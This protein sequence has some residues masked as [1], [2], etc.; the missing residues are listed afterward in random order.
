MGHCMVTCNGKRQREHAKNYDELVTL[1]Q[2]KYGP[3][4]LGYL[5]K[6]R[7]VRFDNKSHFDRICSGLVSRFQEGEFEW[8]LVGGIPGCNPGQVPGPMPG[9]MPGFPGNPPGM[10]A[11]VPR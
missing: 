1:L 10:P 11:G 8:V 3:G 9:P 4:Y 2:Q 7:V 6:G 5:D